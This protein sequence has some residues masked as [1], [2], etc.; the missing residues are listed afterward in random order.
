MPTFV[1][2]VDISLSLEVIWVCKVCPV[3]IKL[4]VLLS[5]F[6]L[7]TPVAVFKAV[8]SPSLSTIKPETVVMS[9]DKV[10]PVVTR[11]EVIALIS[12]SFDVICVCSV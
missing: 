9:V 5:V 7:R 4:A 2:N 6:V 12:E 1:V 10:C 11:L 8:I 3:V